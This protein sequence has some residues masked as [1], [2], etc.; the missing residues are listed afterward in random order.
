MWM[1]DQWFLQ[2]HLVDIIYLLQEVY[3]I[4]IRGW[5]YILSDD[6]LQDYGLDY[7]TSF[8]QSKLEFNRFPLVNHH[9][10]QAK[11]LKRYLVEIYQTDEIVFAKNY[12][13]DQ[14]AGCGYGWGYSRK[15]MY[16]KCTKH[17]S[18]LHSWVAQLWHVALSQKQNMK[19]K[20]I[21]MCFKILKAGV[22][23]KKVAQGL[24][25][26]YVQF[27]NVIMEKMIKQFD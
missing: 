5:P 15:E 8:I 2:L 1:D 7:S 6:K 18:W 3:L 4:N 12:V 16:L 13:K 25:P 14:Q 26:D 20:A 24:H 10:I 11:N 27:K 9:V 17:I 23:T 19:I 21:I 22:T